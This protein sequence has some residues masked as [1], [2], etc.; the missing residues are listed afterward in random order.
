MND[1]SAEIPDGFK[2][3]AGPNL[4]A[5]PKSRPIST[6]EKIPEIVKKT[7]G[8][9][10][11]QK[12]KLI[13]PEK[14]VKKAA[15]EA[16]DVDQPK[17]AKVDKTQPE[18]K[19]FSVGRTGTIAITPS[20]MTFYPSRYGSM[21]GYV[22][23]NADNAMIKRPNTDPSMKTQWGKLDRPVSV[24]GAVSLEFQKKL[25]EVMLS[26]TRG[27]LDVYPHEMV[28]GIP[29]FKLTKNNI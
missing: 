25:V 6:P 28:N 3:P 9:P 7:R 24:R 2:Q 13:E 19:K 10:R 8:R 16:M 12:R 21:Q 18:N 4:C 15:S 11:K 14:V 5:R 23:V 26:K 27:I 1:F 17:A 29:T 22:Y 20:K